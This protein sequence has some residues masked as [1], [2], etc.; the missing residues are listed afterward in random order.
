MLDTKLEMQGGLGPS[1]AILADVEWNLA[2]TGPWLGFCV[3]QA[4]IAYLMG[5]P[6]V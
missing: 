4:K 2:W 5:R 3:L 6:G 1:Q